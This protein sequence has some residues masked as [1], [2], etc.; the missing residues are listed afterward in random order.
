MTQSPRPLIAGNWKMHGTNAFASDLAG[1]LADKMSDAGNNG[2]DMLLCPPGLLL[3]AVRAAI[4]DSAVALGGQDCHAAEQGAHTGDTSA[5]MLKDAGCAYVIVGHSERR[6]DH[7]EDDA[8]V[9]AKASAAQTNGL[10]PV[11][12]IGETLAEREAG[13]AVDVVTG[14]LRGSI[15]GGSSAANMVVA[16]EPVWAIGTG[17]TPTLDDIAEV[18]DAIRAALKDVSNDFESVRILY[19]G[20]VKPENATEILAVANVNGALVGGA[21]LKADDFWAIA[22]A[23]S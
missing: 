15:P 2:V 8:A 22:E 23:A 4:G 12:C 18:H 6:A 19:G 11:I 3:G 20:S 5:A 16:Y 7:D 9:N 10:V 13:R 17:R 1:S 21:S 14:Q